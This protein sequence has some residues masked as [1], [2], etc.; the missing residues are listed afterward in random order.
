MFVKLKLFDDE[1]IC[2]RNGLYLLVVRA[3][4]FATE[5]EI[6]FGSFDFVKIFCCGIFHLCKGGFEV[7]EGDKLCA[8]KKALMF[9]ILYFF[10]IDRFSEFLYF[11]LSIMSRVDLGRGEEMGNCLHIILLDSNYFYFCRPKNIKLLIRN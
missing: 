9:F 8:S 1:V 10:G 6:R 7:W 11:A 2:Q 5:E 4:S 3:L